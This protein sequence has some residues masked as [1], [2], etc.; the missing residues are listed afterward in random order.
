MFI[1][2]IIFVHDR[3]LLSGKLH[4]FCSEFVLGSCVETQDVVVSTIYRHS[5]PGVV[6]L[7]R[8]DC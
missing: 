4:G 5:V 3:Q 8:W 2:C 6:V 1:D 7:P